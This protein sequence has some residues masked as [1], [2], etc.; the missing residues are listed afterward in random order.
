[1]RL[2]IQRVK[3]A[4]VDVDGRSVGQIK[5]WMLVF[6]GVAKTDTLK[7]VDY[8]ISKITQLRL[9]EDGAGKT[10]RSIKDAGGEFLVVPQFT[11]LGD[12][13]KGR[14]PSFDQAASSELGEEL[15]HLFVERLRRGNYKVET[16][17]FRTRMDV[18]LVNDG[19]VTFILESQD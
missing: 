2:V 12:C 5:K 10:N 4:Q 17:R 9:F 11:L 18:A 19:P 16:G 14:R 1:M 13:A 6:L 3:Q 15:Y 7:E 8:L